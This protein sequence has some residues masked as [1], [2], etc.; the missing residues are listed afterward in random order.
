[1]KTTK[2]VVPFLISLVLHGLVLLFASPLTK[3]T[4]KPKYVKV[5][6]LGNGNIKNKIESK[7]EKEIV[8][9]EKEKAKKEEEDLKGQVVDLPPDYNS[10]R[11]ENAKFLSETDHKTEHETIS[12][13][14]SLSDEQS[15]HEKTKAHDIKN[16]G[17]KD[18]G[19]DDNTQEEQHKRELPKIKER[20]RLALKKDKSG[21]I[22]NENGS[23]SLDGN[24]DS[25]HLGQHDKDAKESNKGAREL[26]LFPDQSVLAKI[27]SAPFADA[28]EDVDE[29]EGTFLNTF[30]FKYAT[31]YNRVK[32]DVA[33]QWHPLIELRRRDPTGNI[34]GF[35]NRQTVLDIILDKEGNVLKIN[36]RSS[37]GVG[38]LDQEAVNAFWRVEQF[39]N[40]PSGLIKNGRVRFDFGFHIDFNRKSLF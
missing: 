24:G 29:G 11:P 19:T 15:G 14:R 36:I 20:E 27:A 31:F 6:L 16:T 5:T 22:K 4:D 25:L 9:K 21:I 12:R 18:L 37:C 35:R 32:R 34:Y 2:W 10:E 23:D 30:A 8:K 28:V 38:F 17:A 3:G 1:M 39:P 33:N 40:P 26:Q 13:N 7:I